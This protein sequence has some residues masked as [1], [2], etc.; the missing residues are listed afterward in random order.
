MLVKHDE[1]P[2]PH[3][4]PRITLKPRLLLPTSKQA[5]QPGENPLLLHFEA[6]L[7]RGFRIVHGA[8]GTDELEF[9]IPLALHEAPRRHTV[10]AA[11]SP[12]PHVKAAV[13]LSME[14]A[15]LN[16]VYRHADGVNQAHHVEQLRHL[17]RK[18]LEM[19]LLIRRPVLHEASS[20]CN[21]TNV[22]YLKPNF[23]RCAMTKRHTQPPH[24]AI[25]APTRGAGGQDAQ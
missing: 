2:L 6:V 10:L 14:L 8:V 13:G 20:N 7:A 18:L 17:G 15:V 25:I 4:E 24:R 9:R 12:V 23:M 16:G 11:G 5:Q 3:K 1:S 19:S 22:V 21:L